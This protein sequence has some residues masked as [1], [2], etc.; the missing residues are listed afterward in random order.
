MNWTANAACGSEW[1][2]LSAL[3]FYQKRRR[4]QVMSAGFCNAHLQKIELQKS[5]I[6]AHF[7]KK[8]VKSMIFH[9]GYPM[10]NGKLTKK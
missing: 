4:A 2:G 1:S 7:S 9:D 5:L 10:K 3:E 8:E 6:F